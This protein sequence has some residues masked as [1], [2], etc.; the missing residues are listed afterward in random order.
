MNDSLLIFAASSQNLE[1]PATVDTMHET[2]EPA[3]SDQSNIK[4]VCP[5][6]EL[7]VVIE[8]E[9]TQSADSSVSKEEKIS[10]KI[11]L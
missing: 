2:M 9:E 3:D 1:E 11:N 5:K 7:A 6:D 4:S 8:E 10:E